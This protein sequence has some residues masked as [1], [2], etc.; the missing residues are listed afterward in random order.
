[1]VIQRQLENTVP[2]RFDPG[3]EIPQFQRGTARWNMVFFPLFE[4]P[5]ICRIRR[6]HA[7]N[8]FGK[9][10]QSEFC[11]IEPDFDRLFFMSFSNM[12]N[13]CQCLAVFPVDAYINV[14]AGNDTRRLFP[15]SDKAGL[16]HSEPAVNPEKAVEYAVMAPAAG[17][18]RVVRQGT[19]QKGF[20]DPEFI[21]L[22]IFLAAASPISWRIEPSRSPFWM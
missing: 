7:V 15:I 20:G 3:S 19:G 22:G 17:R 1:M 13:H 21:E 12:G 9:R 8:R 18:Q 16:R 2:D 6:C 10:F 4:Q 11:G 14:L 5:V